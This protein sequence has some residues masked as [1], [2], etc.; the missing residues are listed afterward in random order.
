MRSAGRLARTLCGGSPR[1]RIGCSRRYCGHFRGDGHNA[2]DN[3]D[4]VQVRDFID[5]QLKL[6]PMGHQVLVI[7]PY[8]KWGSKKDRNTRPEV[9]AEES[10]SLV[11]TLAGWKV[12]DTMRVGLTSYRKQTFFGPGNVD[13]IALKVQQDKRVSAVFVSTNVLKPVQH[14]NL[15]NRFRVPVYDRYLMVIQIF[16]QHA[17]TREAKLQVALAEVPYIWSRIR[18]VHEGY[19]E[20]LG[21]EAGQIALSGNLGFDDKKDLLKEY[22]KKLKRSVDKL[23]GHRGHLR[24]GRKGKDLPVVAVVGYTNA[25][26]TSLVRALTGDHELAPRDCLF[27]TLD[28]TVHGGLLPSNVRVLYVDTIGF[29]SDIPTR[30]IEPFVATLEDA[31]FADVIVHVTDVSHPNADVQ[32]RHVENTLKDLSSDVDLLDRVIDVSNK[33]DRLAGSPQHDGGATVMVSCTTGTGLDELKARI[34]ERVMEVTGRR[35]IKIRVRTGREEYEWLRTHTAVVGVQADGEHSV[36]QVVVTESDLDVFRS[37][38]IRK[39]S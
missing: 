19:A 13:A 35:T 31:M 32:K 28:V 12:V 36:V 2:D 10:E 14:Q 39:K 17:T 15:E 29:I 16:R 11:R 37:L 24:H 27:A 1:A 34:E 6:A 33:V 25:G 9:K 5:R 30:L 23:R 18:G 38:F 4:D 8:I 20:R 7:Q 26:K 22:E 21:T 3:E